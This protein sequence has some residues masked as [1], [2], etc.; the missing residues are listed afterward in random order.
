M[1]C[2]FSVLLLQSLRKV[3]GELRTAVLPRLTVAANL[4]IIWPECLSPSS[5]PQKP[6]KT[7]GG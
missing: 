2:V 7:S 5:S 4:A 6:P 1:A 3:M